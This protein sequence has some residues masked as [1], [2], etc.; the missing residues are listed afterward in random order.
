LV[1]RTIAPTS[2]IASLLW[3]KTSDL[4]SLPPSACDAAAAGRFALAATIIRSQRWSSNDG[5]GGA[6]VT[7]RG[8][9]AA[10][11]GAGAG[12]GSQRRWVAT[13]PPPLSP[14]PPPP[15]TKHHPPIVLGIESSFDDT[16]VGIVDGAG[17]VLASIRRTHPQSST[18]G[19]IPWEAG[20]R[21]RVRALPLALF[22]FSSPFPP[23]TPPP[24]PT[25]SFTLNQQEGPRSSFISSFI[26]NLLPSAIA[27]CTLLPH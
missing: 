5:A 13:A 12:A 19:T 6:A 21:H 11:A 14:S 20:E 18:G 25:P 3:S 1:C 17:Q 7:I 4:L 22:F 8:A 27:P 9:G 10:V 15:P 2:S 24:P 23:P 16:A 26:L